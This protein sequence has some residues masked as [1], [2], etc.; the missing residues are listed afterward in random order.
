MNITIVGAGYV[1]LTVA[2]CFAHKGHNV[3]CADI[4][5]AIVEKIN[6]GIS[7]IYEEGL[8]PLLKTAVNTGQ[9]RATTDVKTA[10]KNSEVTLVCVP[11]PSTDDG[12]IDLSLIKGAT[13]VIGSALN[14]TGKRPIVVVKS[15][16]LP[17]T[18]ENVVVPIIEKESGM[19]LKDG[20]GVCVNP[21][22]LREGQAIED[23]L[24]PKNT[25][26]IIGESDKTSGDLLA[27]LYAGF[28]AEILRTDLR[29][30]EMIKYSRNAYLAKDISFANEVAN[31]CSAL[32]IDYLNV[33]KGL[34]MD[35][36]IGK[37]RFLTAGL[38]Y[39][40]S[41]FKKDVTAL[42]NKAQEI[43]VEA[44]LLETTELVNETQPQVAVNLLTGSLSKLDG[45]R[46]AV[47][48]L[49]FKGG[50]D[51]IRE[52]RAIKLIKLLL[53]EGAKVTAYDPK[54]MEKA[55]R[56]LGDSVEF[57][58]SIKEA[59]S[60][61]D[62]CVV[63]TEW[64]QFSDAEIYRNTPLVVDGRRI[65]DKEKLQPSTKYLAIGAPVN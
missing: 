11:T 22:F 7:P 37:G 42:I 29:T 30:A 58:D 60:G 56:T 18:T 20:F 54:A 8:D 6:R 17:G 51:D 62:A 33:K 41:C 3:I 19:K 63:A 47:L 36:R 35:N 25:G 34:E 43:H 39:G 27:K 52:S 28:D 5:E 14:G 4:N 13:K 59:L 44:K 21:E 10:V 15:T 49:A 23:C 65:V 1:G 32:S 57:K 64:P 48:G 26:I 9:L 12:K 46:I 61:C 2:V 45:K 53:N 16:V 24:Q 31:I 38:G 50:T 55:K 40:G